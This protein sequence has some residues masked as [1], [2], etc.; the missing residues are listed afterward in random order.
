MAKIYS[1]FTKAYIIIEWQLY[2]LDVIT[3][4][5]TSHPKW[6]KINLFIS[7]QMSLLKI[8]IKWSHKQ[9]YQQSSSSIKQLSLGTITNRCIKKAIQSINNIK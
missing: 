9:K 1:Y 2:V 7:Y 5:R 6:L 3:F 8:E 4:F